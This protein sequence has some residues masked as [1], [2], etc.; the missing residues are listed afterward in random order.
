[1]LQCHAWQDCR[2]EEQLQALYCRGIGWASPPVPSFSF[3]RKE[4][5][6]GRGD[7]SSFPC[8]QGSGLEHLSSQNVLPFESPPEKGH[9]C[10][11]A[12]A[13]GSLYH[14]HPSLL[15]F[16]FGDCR[17]NR[18]PGVTWR[19]NSVT[20]PSRSHGGSETDFPEREG[21][22]EELVAPPSIRRGEHSGGRGQEEGIP[23]ALLPGAREAC[24]D[25]AATRGGRPGG[26]ACRAA[27][28]LWIPPIS[29]HVPRGAPPCAHVHMKGKL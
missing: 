10:P 13:G 15:S 17:R 3:P 22:E 21:E 16:W 11:S 28:Q 4:G 24:V 23:T 8:T 18:F 6:G 9:L 20:W 12:P 5:K 2:Q 26:A 27:L 25:P 1:M 14:P 19:P 7:A 29:P